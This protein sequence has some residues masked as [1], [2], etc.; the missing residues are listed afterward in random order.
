MERHDREAAAGSDE[1]LGGDKAS[2]KFA[3][4][5]VDRDAQGL[6]GPRR[7]MGQFAAPRRR[8]AGDEL[9]KFKRR[10][11]GASVR[12]ATMARAMRRAARSSPK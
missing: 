7:R 8:D 5:V 12:S 10:V 1:P 3:E 4:L 11:N 2:R 9:G 6:K